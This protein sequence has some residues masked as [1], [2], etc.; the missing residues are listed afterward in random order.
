MLT[1]LKNGFNGLSS[2]HGTAKKGISDADMVN[3]N[4]VQCNTKRTNQQEKE[5]PEHSVKTLLNNITYV[6]LETGW[7]RWN[8]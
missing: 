8:I 2:R 5:R 1:Q 4:Y 3:R 7:R 6:Q